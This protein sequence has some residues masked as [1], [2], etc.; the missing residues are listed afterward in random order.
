MVFF[1]EGEFLIRSIKYF[2]ISQSR[3]IVIYWKGLLQKKNNCK[4]KKKNYWKGLLKKKLCN[5]IETAFQLYQL[6]VGWR[7]SEQLQNA[8]VAKILFFVFAC[9]R[10]DCSNLSNLL[11]SIY[12]YID[13]ITNK[14][15]E[16][17]LQNEISCKPHIPVIIFGIKITMEF[18]CCPFLLKFTVLD[19]ASLFPV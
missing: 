14:E 12:S 10:C 17:F 1:W 19:L 18:L 7:F 3:K 2:S 6:F 5:R 9:Q 4:K 16:Q 11:W 8:D 13:N 15:T